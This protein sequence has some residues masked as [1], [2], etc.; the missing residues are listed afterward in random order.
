[1]HLSRQQ[2][3]GDFNWP[4]TISVLKDFHTHT[5]IKTTGLNQMKSIDPTYKS[6]SDRDSLLELYSVLIEMQFFHL[7]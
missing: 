3:K 6:L 2:K 4:L 7:F 1:M 5:D